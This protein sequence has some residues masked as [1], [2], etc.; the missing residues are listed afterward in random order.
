MHC[1]DVDGIVFVVAQIGD[2]LSEGEEADGSGRG[3][4]VLVPGD[5]SS[6]LFFAADRLPDFFSSSFFIIKCFL[7][8]DIDTLALQDSRGSGAGN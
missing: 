2:A 1:N 5:S 7:C 3:L 6:E 4:A 8:K